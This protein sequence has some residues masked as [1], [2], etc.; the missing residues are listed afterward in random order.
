MN[1]Y[2]ISVYNF[3]SV[4]WFKNRTVI[5]AQDFYPSDSWVYFISTL[6]E[7]ESV[8]TLKLVLQQLIGFQNIQQQEIWVSNCSL[9][10]QT[11]LACF[12]MNHPAAAVAESPEEG[13]EEG[14]GGEFWGGEEA[15]EHC[16]PGPAPPPQPAAGARQERRAD[17]TQ[18]GA[19]HP[20]PA[21]A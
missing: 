4:Y 14:A 12:E 21:A 11:L 3:V 19:P 2:K 8:E 10:T 9:F 13:G 17:W 6:Y 1:V 18:P 16:P 20:G 7:N 15:S 5:I